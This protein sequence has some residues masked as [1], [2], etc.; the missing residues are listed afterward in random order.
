MMFF[1]VALTAGPFIIP[2]SHYPKELK[3]MISPV[4]KDLWLQVLVCKVGL[5]F[6]SEVWGFG[7]FN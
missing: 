3:V 7:G 5:E 2:D 6:P 4:L 1:E